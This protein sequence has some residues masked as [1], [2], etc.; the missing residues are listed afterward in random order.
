M[1]SRR[2]G[3]ARGI[4]WLLAA[5]L[6]A[7]VGPGCGD[8][9]PPDPACFRGYLGEEPQSL[10][11]AFAVDE[12]AGTLVS[13]IYPGLFRFDPAGEPQSDLAARWALEA[14]ERRYRIV[15]APGRRFDDGTPITAPLVR[16]CF[17]R[18]LDPASPSPRRWVLAR[19]KGAAA[20]RD[21]LAAG[22]SGLKAPDDSTLVLELSAPFAPFLGL[23]A[24]P[25]TRVYPQAA[26]GSPARQDGLPIA[27]GP[28]RLTRWEPGDLLLLERRQPAPPG[29]MQRLALRIIPQPFTAVAE[30]EVGN[31]DLL[32]VPLAEADFWLEGERR[33]QVLR[34]DELVV[35]Y[36]GLNVRRAPFDD[37]RVRQ[38][39][40]H[41]IDV[42]ALIRTLRAKAARR[43][44]G[45][46]P[47]ALRS[48]D[49]GE[50]FRYRPERARELLAEAGY[51]QG[52]A[53]EIWQKENPEV[54]RLLEAVQA[55]LAEVG[56][57]ARI[58]VR[59][60]GAFKDAVNQGSADAFFLDWLADY[61]DAEN[62]LVPLFHSRNLGGG[63]NRAGFAETYVDILLDELQTMPPG[64][65]RTRLVDR[66]NETIYRE[67]PWIWLWHPVALEALAPG[68]SGYRPP[69]IFNG[70]DYLELRRDAALPAS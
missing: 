15:L 7:G 61:P 58:V 60:W 50:L 34:Q 67:A 69:L 46:V 31:L 43:A 9:E 10:D 66:L 1:H 44:L 56:I 21:G 30:Y 35:S 2:Q 54:G 52:F 27:G 23:L 18:L 5:L 65:A 68:L 26:D 37:R 25:A 48:S 64:P 6:A 47:P 41:A 14:G 59:D 17:L 45:P 3:G 39:L 53:M 22:V 32:R 40:N 11:P 42:E 70:Q 33:G 49:P 29:G 36:I 19:L 51:A 16:S 24:M 20:Y 12:A 4:A 13:L 28:W 8:R 38:A 62:F 55:Y 57:E 63:G